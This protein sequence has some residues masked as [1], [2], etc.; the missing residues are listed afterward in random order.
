MAEL[1]QRS[2]QGQNQAVL[3]METPL[4]KLLCPRLVN[5]ECR[6]L[7]SDNTKPWATRIIMHAKC[8]SSG[9][10]MRWTRT[11][12]FF[13]R[14][15]SSWDRATSSWKFRA[16]TPTCLSPPTTLRV[17]SLC[18]LS[19]QKGELRTFWTNSRMTTR[20]WPTL[21]RWWT[22][23]SSCL[24]LNLPA[25]SECRLLHREQ[26]QTF[27]KSVRQITSMLLTKHKAK[28]SFQTCHS[29]TTSRNQKEK[30]IKKK[31]NDLTC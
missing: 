16:I 18:W 3:T 12:S 13:T 27:T 8:R 6:P 25:R 23:A 21:C 20:P 7:A 11:E 15:Q 10:R 22:S 1:E 30:K 28:P 26:G 4:T 31:W 17:Q 24:T 9:R 19:C 5:E 2:G 29:K 14:S